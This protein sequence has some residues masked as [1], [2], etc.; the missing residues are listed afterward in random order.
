MFQVTGAWP[1]SLAG[2]RARRLVP[3]PIRRAAA[4]F[5]GDRRASEIDRELA[6]V[7]SDPR[8]IVAGPWLGEVGFELLYWVPFVRWFAERYAI[9]PGRLIAVSRGGASVWYSSFPA[10][11][12]DALAFMSPEEFRAKNDERNRRF[13][14][15]KQLAAAAL[16][17]EILDCVRRELGGDVA[18]LH[19]SSMYRVFAPYWWGHRSL[20]WIRRRARY[21]LL[22]PP[23]APPDLPK[24][25]TAVKFYFNDCFRSTPENR[26]FVERTVRALEREGPVI[27]LSTGLSLDDHTPCEP[28]IAGANRIRHLLLAQTNLLVQSAVVAHARRF[29]GTYGGFAY[30]APFYGVP[31]DSFYTEPGA[32]S[33]RHLDLARDVIGST[34]GAGG[35]T[36]GDIR[37]SNF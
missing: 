20:E 31:A 14:E 12:Y 25:Y 7:A 3:A 11:S 35:L 37:T 27:A 34:P 16:D 22:E 9:D 13:G 6:D 30:L 29:V 28:D 21:R 4:R 18:V 17:A 24:D 1:P 19:P 32:F 15:Q 23:A 26:A 2:S 8:P 10:Q 5:V 33:M 36:V